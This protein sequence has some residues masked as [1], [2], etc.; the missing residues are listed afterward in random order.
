M[1]EK[2]IY[3]SAKILRS[4]HDVEP[5]NPRIEPRRPI[6][7]DLC[8]DPVQ[9]TSFRGIYLVFVGVCAMV[10][11]GVFRNDPSRVRIHVQE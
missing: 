7:A 8:D 11:Y 4:W 9:R 3:G 5:L 1:V 10:Y 6:T 2:H